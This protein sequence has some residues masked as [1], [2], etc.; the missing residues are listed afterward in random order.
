MGAWDAGRWYIGASAW[1]KRA[2]PV[3]LSC[4]TSCCRENSDYAGMM[5]RHRRWC[6]DGWRCCGL[7]CS[8][9]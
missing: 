8:G 6:M 9:L 4:G 2:F 3:A 5:F 1:E 7:P